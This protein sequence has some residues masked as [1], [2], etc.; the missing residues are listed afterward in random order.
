ML[1][2]IPHSPEVVDQYHIDRKQDLRQP[3]LHILRLTRH[4]CLL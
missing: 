1:H 4:E 3:V 2:A